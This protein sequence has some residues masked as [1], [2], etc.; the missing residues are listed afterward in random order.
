MINA[1]WFL[2]QAV[3]DMA[4]RAA[5]RDTGSERS[6]ERTV[7]AFNA[8]HDKDLTPVQGWQFMELLKMARSVGGDFR[9]DDFTDGAAYAALAG[10]Q[11][12][13][14]GALVADNNSADAKWKVVDHPITFGMVEGTVEKS[15]FLPAAKS[16]II[17][18]DMPVMDEDEKKTFI[19]ECPAGFNFYIRPKKHVQIPWQRVT[20]VKNSYMS[21]DGWI[22]VRV[23][24]ETGN[25]GIDSSVYDFA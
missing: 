1:D 3:K 25:F 6:M 10:E 18:P 11:A 23:D 17:N 5:S 13:Q 12:S 19:N 14:K 8:I 7:N 21:W 2:N 20:L 9:A 4:D 24:D 16:E 22:T 15:P